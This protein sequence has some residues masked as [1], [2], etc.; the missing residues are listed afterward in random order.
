MTSSNIEKAERIGGPRRRIVLINRETWPQHRPWVVLVVAIAL[1]AT[2]WEVT[3]RVSERSWPSGGSLPGLTFGVVGGLI[4]LF[5]FALWPRKKVRVW[6]IGRAQ[7]WLRAHIWLGLLT[8]PLIAFHSGFRLGGPLAT[9]LLVLFTI[10]ILSGLFG[11]ALQ[12]FLPRKMLD[13]VPAE[14]I[15]SQ[16]DRVAS[17]QHRDAAALVR[18][19]CGPTPG[20]PEQDEDSVRWPDRA[21][22]RTGFVTVGALRSAGRVAGR[23]LTTR[24]TTGAIAGSEPI[25]DFFRDALGPYLLKGASSRSTLVDPVRSNIA[26]RELKAQTNPAASA[27]IE[28]LEGLANQRRQLDHE[29]RIHRVLHGWLSVHLPLSVGLMVL[30]F[31]HIY[32]ALRYW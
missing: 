31:L 19:T 32:V 28:E 29:A 22:E 23:V 15:Y 26:F 16:I 12:Q 27:V 9:T 13:E 17:L 14:T 8:I 1:A 30:M 5:E 21:S 11:L 2:A 4:M 24:T 6:R 10:V 18:S 7:A 3:V 20:E 25:R